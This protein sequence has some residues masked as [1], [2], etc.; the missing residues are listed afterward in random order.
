MEQAEMDQ[1]ST[2]IYIR[3]MPADLWR[4]LKVRAAQEGSTLQEQLTKALQQYLQQNG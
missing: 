3:V 2:K 1:Q 4:Q